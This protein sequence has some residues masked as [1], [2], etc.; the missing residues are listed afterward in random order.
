MVISGL[1]PKDDLLIILGPYNDKA[2]QAT[3]NYSEVKH[4]I[5]KLLQDDLGLEVLTDTPI[6]HDKGVH[7]ENLLHSDSNLEA[8]IGSRELQIELKS[9]ARRPAIL[10]RLMITKKSLHHWLHRRLGAT[11]M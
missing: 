7:L 3:N 11:N 6:A 5:T 10:Q 8:N 4:V 1:P 2:N 9:S